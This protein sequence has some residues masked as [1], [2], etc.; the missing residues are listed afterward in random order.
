MRACLPSAHTY[1]L[2]TPCHRPIRPRPLEVLDDDRSAGT[3]YSAVLC[4]CCGA[5]Y[6][7]ERAIP[8]GISV[9]MMG[10]IKCVPSHLTSPGTPLARTP[11]IPVQHDL[12]TPS[13]S[14]SLLS[15]VSSGLVLLASQAR[16]PASPTSAPR[17]ACPGGG[18]I[19]GRRPRLTS[20]WK[21]PEI[22]APS[23]MRCIGDCNTPK[24]R[25]AARSPR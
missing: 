19:P 25:P 4:P 6:M 8:G 14:L 20:H 13:R 3:W 7:R 10:A 17:Y 21:P 18:W 1:W 22:I 5:Y 16:D 12:D 15:C 11:R 23:E 2:G 24:D 9:C